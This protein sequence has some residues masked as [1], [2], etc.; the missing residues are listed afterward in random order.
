MK[1]LRGA[2]DTISGEIETANEALKKLTVALSI[3]DISTPK[4]PLD[5]RWAFLVNQMTKVGIPQDRSI[6]LINE[7]LKKLA[8][9]VYDLSDND[10]D[11]LIRNDK[12]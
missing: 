10:I 12:A 4:L 5:G 8:P 7:E 9:T 11:L 2:H 6:Y 1:K 3:S